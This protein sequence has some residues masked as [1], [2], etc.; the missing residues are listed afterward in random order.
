[1]SHCLKPND[2]KV[3]RFEHG[4]VSTSPVM[5]SSATV[6]KVRQNLQ[7]FANSYMVGL[8]SRYTVLYTLKEKQPIVAQNP[9]HACLRCP[10]ISARAW[11]ALHCCQNVT[12]STPL[13]AYHLHSLVGMKQSASECRVRFQMFWDVGNLAGI[14]QQQATT[15]TAETVNVMHVGAFI[16]AS[17]VHFD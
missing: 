1:M 6:N 8:T 3:D 5:P 9:L 15:D 4:Q 16:C 7:H 11:A 14:P 13:F 2:T 17:V 10:E 12:I